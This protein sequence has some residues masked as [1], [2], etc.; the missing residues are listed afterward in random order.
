MKKTLVLLL[1]AAGMVHADYKWQGGNTITTEKWDNQANWEMT[2]GTTWRTVNDA[3]CP[4]GPGTTNSEMWDPIYIENASGTI[5]NLEGWQ[6]NLTLVNTGLRVD[7]L[8]KF[9]NNTGE[10]CYINID[11]N[12]S[13]WVNEFGQYGSDGEEVYLNCEGSFT[14]YYNKDQGGSGIRADLGSTGK[15]Q[16][17]KEGNSTAENYKASLAYLEA[18][19]NATSLTLGVIQ[20]RSLVEVVKGVVMATLTDNQIKINA[21]EDWVSVTSA[22]EVVNDG[23]KYYWVTQSQEGVKLNYVATD[24]I[25]EPT[26]ATLSLLA[27]AG[28]AARRRRK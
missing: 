26:T 28:L 20:A 6:L 25:P 11:A 23:R 4:D 27:L 13:L 7:K 22:D 24:S 14:M 10:G 18:D 9:Q 21:S 8:V 3:P 1:A 5:E 12:S 2:N 17:Q 19:L 15:I 16:L